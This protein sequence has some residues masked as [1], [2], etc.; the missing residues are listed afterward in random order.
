MWLCKTVTILRYTA[1]IKAGGKRETMIVPGRSLNRPAARSEGSRAQGWPAGR[2]IIAGV[3]VVLVALAGV[4]AAAL[5]WTV[6]FGSYTT[7]LPNLAASAAP[8]LV[9]PDPI[10]ATGSAAN[11]FARAGAPATQIE[12]LPESRLG[13]ALY[14]VRT[15]SD[16]RAGSAIIEA[17]A[18]GQRSIPAGAEVQ[19]GIT[20]DEVHA[21]RVVLNRRGVREVVY[22][23]DR[24]RRQAASAAADLAPVAIAGVALSP[25]P[26]ASGGQG[27]RVDGDPG[28]LGALGIR[29]GDVIASIDGQPLTAALAVNLSNRMAQGALPSSLTLERDGE[30]VTLQT[31]PN[32]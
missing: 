10:A 17:G 16:P 9:R 1:C 21:D 19:S 24:A 11:L 15:A 3:E 8:G 12:V 26:L 6:I 13:F 32:P 2:L 30:R 5:G 25:Q 4:L 27:L 20:L 22:L 31:R 14:G 28:P 23:T 7:P 29:T 18:G